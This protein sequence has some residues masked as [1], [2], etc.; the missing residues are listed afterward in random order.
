MVVSLDKFDKIVREVAQELE[1]GSNCYVN[2]NTLEIIALP[3]F[4]QSGD[5]DFFREQF[6]DDIKKVKKHKKELIE[7][8]VLPSSDSFKIMERFTH[9][10][11]DEEFQA[12]LLDVLANRK[13]FQNFK[14]AVDYS[15]YRQDWFDF[16]AKEYERLVERQLR[17][18]LN[19]DDRVEE[20][21]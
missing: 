2:K 21:E 12:E 17:L 8:E 16:K 10:L 3:D 11:S 14:R 5:D 7:F 4:S 18:E 9:H 13:P 6:K 1:C 20:D 15:D 19:M